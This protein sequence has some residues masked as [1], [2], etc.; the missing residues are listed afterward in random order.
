[1]SPGREES[2]C[3]LLSDY[4]CKIGCLDAPGATQR[5]GHNAALL[6]NERS[7]EGKIFFC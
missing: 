7:S 5:I 4:K 3:G 2:I 1:M 6:G